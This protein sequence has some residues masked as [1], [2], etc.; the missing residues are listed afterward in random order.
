MYGT[1]TRKKNI[2]KK[3]YIKGGNYINGVN[4]IT[5]G[6]VIA[7]GGFGCVFDPPLRCKGK[8]REKNKVSKLMIE[9]HVVSEYNEIE[10]IKKVLKKI[11]NYENY[12]LVDDFSMCE[13][14]KLDSEDLKNFKKKCSA[15][16]KKNISE[17]NINENLDKL[18]VLNMP[19]GGIPIDDY[20]YNIKDYKDLIDLNNRLINLLNN[21]IIPMN[22]ENIYHTDVKDANILISSDKQRTRLIDWGLT[23][24]YVPNVDAEFP[25]KWKNRS[26]QF[27]IPFSLIIFS[28]TFLEQYTKYIKDSS[29][30]EKG[31]KEKEDLK[32]F[33]KRYFDYW[34]KE[35]GLG[36]FKYLN[37]IMYL[38]FIHDIKTG[39]ITSKTM[40]ADLQLIEKDYTIPY[41]VN[42]ITEIL[43]HFTKFRKDGGIN[44]RVYLDTVFIKILDIWGLILCYL[45]IMDIL[46]DN[47]DKL[48][49]TELKLFNIIKHL[50]LK[51]LYEPRITPINIV[52][53]THDLKSINNLF[54]IQNKDNNTDKNNLIKNIT[55]NSSNNNSNSSTN[56]SKVRNTSKIL[57]PI[58]RPDFN[59]TR[60]KRNVGFL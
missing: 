56:K 45:P 5:G 36:H 7:S 50:I 59:N 24:E 35:R 27:N 14:E 39:K 60:K 49:E 6:K 55:S 41:V 23:T 1:K 21:G 48:T 40:K 34:L 20:I 51:Y 46:F 22:R 17:K 25:K 29:N 54:E 11:P 52:E 8:Q 18:L 4:Y 38:L 12:Y 19:H 16:P 53:L 37:K 44:L 43:V 32:S 57:T 2:K 31:E 42:Y 33:V 3:K 15:L 13:P 26:I 30:K 9:R 10:Q 58:I 28:D 47:Y